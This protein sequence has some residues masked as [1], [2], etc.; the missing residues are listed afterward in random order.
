MHSEQRYAETS[1]D[2]CNKAK[3]QAPLVA[4]LLLWCLPM[5]RAPNP[6][7]LPNKEPALRRCTGGEA[8]HAGMDMDR[9][10][11][12]ELPRAHSVF[13]KHAVRRFRTA[14]VDVVVLV[15]V[16]VRLV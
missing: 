16:L 2:K 8:N 11:M 7:A 10:G 5:M 15:V 3:R 12:A 6:A 14:V 9:L 13:G 1:Q 4:G